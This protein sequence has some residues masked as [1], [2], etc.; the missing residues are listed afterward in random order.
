[1]KL[2]SFLR[3]QGNTYQ[4]YVC[5]T[6]TS[7]GTPSQQKILQGAAPRSRGNSTGRGSGTTKALAFLQ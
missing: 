7:L 6:Y 2:L 1:M 3:L 4:L 5:M